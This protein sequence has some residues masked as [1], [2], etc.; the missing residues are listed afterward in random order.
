MYTGSTEKIETD[1]PATRSSWPL[2]GRSRSVSLLRRLPS[3]S[4]LTA[5]ESLVVATGE[6]APVW[7]STFAMWF[8]GGEVVPLPQAATYRGRPSGDRAKPPAPPSTG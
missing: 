6:T 7:V 8:G 1:E 4:R 3:G 2:N 5:T